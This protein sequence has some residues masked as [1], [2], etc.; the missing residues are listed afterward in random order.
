MRYERFRY[1]IPAACGLSEADQQD[2]HFDRNRLLGRRTLAACAYCTSK[3]TLSS[4]LT[5][6]IRFLDPGCERVV[7]TLISSRSPF[8]G[9]RWF[10]HD[11]C[12]HV[13]ARYQRPDLYGS[14]AVQTVH[15]YQV[16]GCQW[17]VVDWILHATWCVAAPV[18]ILYGSYSA[19]LTRS[20]NFS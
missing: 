19:V 15:H 1:Y 11:I 4:V 17:C 3:T 20:S 12:D 7:K 13:N 10:Q 18:Q 8:L 14:A 9:G 16:Q 5:H 2:C 6:A